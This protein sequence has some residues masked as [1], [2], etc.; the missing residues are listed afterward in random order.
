M[1]YFYRNLDDVT[2]N[3]YK[4][5]IQLTE[6]FKIHSKETENLKKLNLKLA[7][8]NETLKGDSNGNNA[9]VKE[10]VEAAGKQAKTIKDVIS[11]QSLYL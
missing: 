4:E 5:N 9:L 7:S 3:I 6:A 10:T 8:E 1:T 2:K 11:I